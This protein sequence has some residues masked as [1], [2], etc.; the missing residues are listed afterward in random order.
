MT[1]QDPTS[2]PTTMT[3][4]TTIHTPSGHEKVEPVV[5]LLFLG[6][7]IFA[8]LLFVSEKFFPSDG[9][10]FQVI[11]GLL[12]G[13]SGA[14]FMRVKPRESADKITSKVENQ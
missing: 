9:Q 7:V 11:A 1:P 2:S 10:F 12:T 5:L 4:S 3:S 6:M 13:F 8:G 14:F